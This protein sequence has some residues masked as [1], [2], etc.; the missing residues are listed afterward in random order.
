MD[1]GPA[2][3]V[4]LCGPSGSGKTR[5]AGRSGLPVF[6]LDDFYKDG[7]DPSMP[8]SDD[9]GIVDWDDVR[10]WHA[11]RAVDALVRLC[12]DGAVEVPTY[13]IAQDRATGTSTFSRGDAAAVVAEGVFA[14]EIVEAC[15]ARGILADAVVLHRAPWKNFLRRLAR[16]LRERRKPPHTLWRRGRIL[17]RTEPARVAAA[18]ARGCR[19]V[20][21]HEL[22]TLLAVLAQGRVDA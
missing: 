16:D 5:I 14:A 11:D 4:L 13:D 18:E 1:E 21:A 7:D 19:P 9:L 20:S 2:R 10:A 15:R 3:V 8:R 6:R 17:M 12:E 22:S